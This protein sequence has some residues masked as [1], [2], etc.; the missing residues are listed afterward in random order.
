M[1]AVVEGKAW[2]TSLLRV[3]GARSGGCQHGNSRQ[4][5]IWAQRRNCSEAVGETDVQNTT[6]T[7]PPTSHPLGKPCLLACSTREGSQD[8]G[9]PEPPA[10]LHPPL[11][12]G[13]GLRDVIASGLGLYDLSETLNP[14]A[15]LLLAADYEGP[16]CG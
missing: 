5:L 13:A 6:T 11:R 12:V 4:L 7:F 8:G 14:E 9:A 1:K 16:G 3:V 10:G 2:A 15:S